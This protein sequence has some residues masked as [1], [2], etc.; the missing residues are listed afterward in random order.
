MGTIQRLLSPVT[1]TA[2]NELFLLRPHRVGDVG[3]VFAQ[4]ALL[5]AR[6]YGWDER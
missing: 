3:T 5:Y 6:E 2:A 4:Q 1:P